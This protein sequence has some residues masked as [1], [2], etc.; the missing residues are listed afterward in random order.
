MII[1]G[2]TLPQ[3]VAHYPATLQMASVNPLQKL[4]LLLFGLMMIIV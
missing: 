2:H 3:K 1:N 4:L